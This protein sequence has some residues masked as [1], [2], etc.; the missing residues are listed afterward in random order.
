MPETRAPTVTQARPIPSSPAT[1]EPSPS[2]QATPSSLPRRVQVAVVGGGLAGLT[3]AR[4]LHRAGFDAHVF[5]P[6][7]EPGGRVRTEV[8]D[9]HLCD[10]GFQVLLTGYPAVRE[11]LDLPALRLHGFE[12]GAVVVRDAKQYSLPDPFRSPDRWI[13]AFLFPLATLLDKVRTRALRRRLIRTEPSALFRDPEQMAAAWLRDQGF[14]ERF[15]S[16]FWI[17]FF[18]A[19]FLDPPLEVSSRLFQF[20]FRSIAAGEI[21]LP[22]RGMGEVARQIQSG[23][24]AGAWHP[25]TRVRELL[26]TDG[27]VRSLVVTPIAE[28]GRA[29]AGQPG[30]GVPSGTQVP[31][32]APVPRDPR[33]EDAEDGIQ[34]RAD[35]VVL[36]CGVEEARRLSRLNLPFLEPLGVSVVYF[37]S[38]RTFTRERRIYL[39]GGGSGP[40]HHVVQLD[41]VCPTYAPSGSHLIEVTVL[42]T[43]EAPEAELAER[44]RRQMQVW[45]PDGGTESWTWLRTYKV[46]MAQ[47]RQPPGLLD[48]L[49]GTRAEVRGLFLAGDYTRHSSVQGALESGRDAAEAVQEDSRRM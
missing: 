3:A 33:G 18:S 16:T 11:E 10:V 42:G 49:P 47:F 7:D 48:R 6:L 40:G 44:V 20:V 25:R 41:N 21:A 26:V 23:L 38:E 29:P 2:P 4:H 46:P 1:R 36:A 35:S 19:V 8:V 39:N 37:R 45:F 34:I 24:A 17:P 22:E 15:L 12:P 28:G 43:P 9:G 31:P 27:A 32:G 14:G 5:D 13:E 30:P